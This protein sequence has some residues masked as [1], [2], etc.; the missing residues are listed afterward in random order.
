MSSAHYKLLMTMMMKTYCNGYVY[1]SAARGDNSHHDH[2]GRAVGN[3]ITAVSRGTAGAGGSCYQH[4]VKQQNRLATRRPPNLFTDIVK[5]IVH[6]CRPTRRSTNS[7]TL[8]TRGSTCEPIVPC[9]HFS[10][11]QSSNKALFF[12][13]RIILDDCRLSKSPID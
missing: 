10:L 1:I 3:L 4:N 7:S 11:F 2:F 6:A 13:K 9:S 8:D 5:Y 12:T